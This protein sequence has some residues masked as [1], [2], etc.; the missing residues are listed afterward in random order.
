MLQAVKLYCEVVS[1][2]EIFYDE[3]KS[4]ELDRELGL[5]LEK[6][7]N[8]VV[9]LMGDVDRLFLPFHTKT[10]ILD[11]ATCPRW[12]LDDSFP[13]VTSVKTRGGLDERCFVHLPKT[14][15]HL[16]IYVPDQH[17][18][19]EYYRS[20]YNINFESFGRVMTIVSEKYE[21]DILQILGK[22]LRK[23]QLD[24]LARVG[25]TRELE[26]I[27]EDNRE[28]VIDFMVDERVKTKLITLFFGDVNDK[29]VDNPDEIEAYPERL[30]AFGRY[31]KKGVIPKWLKWFSWLFRSSKKTNT[32]AHVLELWEAAEHKPAYDKKLALTF[33]V[34]PFFD[35]F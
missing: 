25:N 9:R 33:K 5:E 14:L 3:Y 20:T 24:V 22:P 8:I 7:E 23:K 17:D 12:R 28:E 1:Y 31:M 16:T 30:A 21:L 11:C 19:N 6:C 34:C 15:K 32:K 26:V 2:M 10:L 4:F 29:S 35:R 18:T 13:S 27:V